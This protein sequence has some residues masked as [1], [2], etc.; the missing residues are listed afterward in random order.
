MGG[1]RVTQAAEAAAIASGIISVQPVATQY[2][3]LFVAER[4]TVIEALHLRFVAAAGS[5]RVGQL[6]YVQSGKA[7][8]D[9]SYRVKITE[10]TA[11]AADLDFN[12]TANTNQTGTFKLT[13]GVP[14]N[15]I[16]PAGSLVFVAMDGIAGS[17][18]GVVFT[19][20]Y[21]TV[22]K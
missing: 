15:N 16:V 9:T 11:G 12:G 7:M 19:I 8:S 21:S 13:S 20:R 17:L 1:Q 14:A 6:M 18:D 2:M 3:P 5:A 10:T 4:K 22:I